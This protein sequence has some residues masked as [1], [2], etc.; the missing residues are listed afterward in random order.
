[1]PKGVEMRVTDFLL[2][3]LF[4]GMIAA[5]G[6]CGAGDCGTF[7]EAYC[8]KLAECSPY[9]SSVL[10]T[11]TTTSCVALE[12]DSCERSRTAPGSNVTSDQAGRCGE[13]YR[14]ATCDDIFSLATAAAGDCQ[15][16]GS[17]LT[18]EPCGQSA[19]CQ[20]SNCQITSGG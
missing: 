15:P 6:G 8:A 3:T 9:F 7:A 20:S 2:G 17:R 13:I 11:S 18:G 4:W 16:A 10:A 12:R 1:M 14:K 5:A 19:Q